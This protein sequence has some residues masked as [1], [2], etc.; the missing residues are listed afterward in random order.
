MAPGPTP[1]NL[2]SKSDN[3][4]LLDKHFAVCATVLAAV[5]SAAA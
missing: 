4:K 3:V 2:K 5:Y 1:A